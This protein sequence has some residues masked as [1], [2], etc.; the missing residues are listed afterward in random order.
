LTGYNAV[1]NDAAGY[2]IARY[3]AHFSITFAI[4]CFTEFRTQKYSMRGAYYD[5]HIHVCVTNLHS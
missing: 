5:L 1:H 3:P 2:A 4:R